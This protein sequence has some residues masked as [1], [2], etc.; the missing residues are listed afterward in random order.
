MIKCL[1]LMGLARAADR[2]G[3]FHVEQ[4]GED[5]TGRLEVDTL[6]LLFNL[7]VIREKPGRGH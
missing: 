5:S 4:R 1:W 7:F 3:L 2:S 6:R